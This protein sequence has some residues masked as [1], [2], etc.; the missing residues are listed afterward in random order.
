MKLLLDTCTFLWVITDVKAL[1]NN[2][3]LLFTDPENEVYLSTVS[4]WELL[5]KQG[6]NRLALPTPA[7]Q[8]IL[9]QRRLHR[10]E[11]LALQEE[12][13]AQLLRLPE[14][15]Q[16]PFDRM[17]ICQAIAHSMTLLTPDERINQYPIV[18]I[19]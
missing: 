14:Y 2:A 13:V 10:I 9:E 11:P 7:E 4:V 18:T 6:L 8:F 3:R 5:V 12:A 17:L 19:W 16:D 1:S 15:H